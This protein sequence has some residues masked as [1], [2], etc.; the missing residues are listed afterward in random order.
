M[1]FTS[2]H[3]QAVIDRTA[4]VLADRI[5]ERAG[6]LTE[7]LVL[8]LRTAAQLVGLS[9]RQIGTYLPITETSAGKHGVTVG[10][11][12]RHIESRTQPATRTI[13]FPQTA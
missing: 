1:E 9:T 2:E 8:D 13:K 4:E 7:L 11:I 6:D 3:I 5:E 12:R 10:A